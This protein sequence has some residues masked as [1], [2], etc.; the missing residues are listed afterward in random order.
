MKWGESDLAYFCHLEA[1]RYIFFSVLSPL[2]VLNIPVDTKAI[3]FSWLTVCWNN[4][5]VPFRVFQAIQQSSY[6]FMVCHMKY[7]LGR[8][9]IKLLF[10]QTSF[11]FHLVNSNISFFL[12][13]EFYW[14]Q[15]AFA[16]SPLLLL[17]C[18]GTKAAE[19]MNTC[20]P[21]GRAIQRP[22]KP[23]TFESLPNSMCKS[24]SPQ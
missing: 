20:L 23:T 6:F 22:L 24:I 8:L 16:L 7:L 2:K 11:C 4:G 21:Q 1:I 14:S 17:S 12:Y 13:V 5:L 19:L 15:R 18:M 10:P 3:L 9:R